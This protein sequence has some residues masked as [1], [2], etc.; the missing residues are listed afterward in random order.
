MLYIE[1]SYWRGQAWE[2]AKELA[3]SKRSGLS[4]EIPISFP[5]SVRDVIGEGG[6]GLSL[7]GYERIT[8]SGRSEW[9]SGQV[10]GPNQSK[11]PSLQMEQE[12]RFTITGT[13]GS[14][15]NVTIDQDSK[16][17]TDLENTINISYKGTEDDIIQKIEAGN[18]N[19]SL[20]GATFVGYSERV[21]GLFG[22]KSQFQIGDLSLTVIGSQEKGQHESTTIS[23]RSSV[24]PTEIDDFGYRD[25]TYF[26]IEEEF[27]NEL[28][29]SGLDIGDSIIEFKFYI[30]DRNTSNNIS[31]NAIKGEAMPH[32]GE[33]FIEN[34]GHIGFF[35]IVDQ[36]EYQIVR[37]QGWFRMVGYNTLRSDYGIACQY[38]IRDAVG[39]LDS[40][41]YDVGTD[42]TTF[43]NLIRPPNMLPENPCWDNTWRNIY[44]L[45]SSGLDPD[46]IE[47]EIFLSPVNNNIT[48]DTT[49]SPPLPLVEVFCLDKVD[50][51]GN[52]NPD[53]I[54]DRTRF[55]IGQGFLVFPVLHPFDPSDIEESQLFFGANTGRNSAMYNSTSS[56][57]INSDHKYVIRVKTGSRQNPMS[58][59][60]FNIMEGS[61]IVKLGGR[62]LQKGIDYRVDYQI[63][64]I[65]FLTDEALN[66]NV[67]LNID[68]DYEPFFM[69][70]QKALLGTRAEYR[71]GENSWLGGTVLYKS[72]TSAEN[73]PRVGR[74][75]S[76][77]FIWDTDLRLDYEVPVL[78]SLVDAIPLVHTDR[79]SRI[80]FTAE[81]AQVIGNPNTKNEAYIDDFE[82]VRNIF[83]IEVRRTIWRLSSSPLEKTQENRGRIIWY[84]PTDKVNVKEIWPNKEVAT[85]DSKTNV[86]VLSINDTS[87]VHTTDAW[88]G[89]MRY[90]ASG[91][92][93]QSRS[94]FLEVWVRGNDGKLHFDFGSIDEDIND[95]DE[96]D[97][98]DEPINGIRD[99]I[100]TTEEDVGIDG[101]PDNLEPGYNGSNDPNN[102]NWDWDP[103]DPENYSRI[104]GTEENARDPEG[105]NKPDTE[106]LNGNDFLDRYNNYFEFTID[107]SSDEFEV[108]GTRSYIDGTSEKW[109]LYRIPVQDST[110]TLVPD[111]KVYRRKEIGAP[112]W[113]QIKYI[114]LWADNIEDSTKV[115]IAQMDLVGNKWEEDSKEL[116]VTTKNTHEDAD[117]FSP[118]SVSGERSVTTGI[119]SQEQS[120]VLVFEDVKGGDTLL[121]SCTTFGSEYMNLTLYNQLE[122]WVY[123]N[124]D[125]SDDS[126]MFI[127]R[128]GRDQYN[129]Y[130]FRT[131]LQPGWEDDNKVVIDFS[132]IT[133][134]KDQVFTSLADTISSNDMDRVMDLENGS[135]YAIRG[136]PTLTDIRY[137][138]IGIANPYPYRPIS[139]EIWCD[140]LKVTDV[141][142]EP[143]W[144]E[145]SSFTI[146]FADLMD[147]NGSIERKDSE[148]HNLNEQVGSGAT[149][150]S[151]GV[152][153]KFNTHKFAPDS[154]GLSLPLSLN[155]GQTVSVPRLKTGSDISVPDSLRDEETTRTKQYSVNVTQRLSPKNPGLLVGLTLARLSHSASGG[156]RIEKSPNYPENISQD[157]NV[158]QSYDITPDKKWN[159]HLT[160]WLF[161]NRKIEVDS[162][163]EKS[164]SGEVDIKDFKTEKGFSTAGRD[165][166]E[167]PGFLDWELNLAP[168]ALRFET[169]AAARIQKRT[170]RYGS[171]TRSNEKTLDHT[172]TFNTNIIDPI[173]T[174]FTL[175]MK[176]DIGDSA[177]F[178][179]R[180]PIS[181]G[182]PLTKSIT[183][184][185][186]FSPT[187]TKWL[188][189]SYEFTSTYSE[190]TDPQR[191]TD[192]FG[193]VDVSRTYRVSMGLR[194]REL[195]KLLG[196]TG[197]PSARDPRKPRTWERDTLDLDEDNAAQTPDKK[198]G[199]SQAIGSAAGLLDRFDDVQFDWQRDDRRGLPNLAS[200]PSTA[201]QLGFT[202]DP[203]VPTVVGST[204]VTSQIESRTI[205]DNTTIRTGMR[206]PM[207]ISASL[208]YN[209][210]S[211]Q[212]YSTNNTKDTQLSFPDLTVNWNGLGKYFFFP[213][214]ASNVRTNAHYVHEKKKSYQSGD[215]VTRSKKHDLSPLV[216]MSIG[217]KFGLNTDYSTNWRDQ[218]DY[219]YST[220]NTSVTHSSEI[221]H[222]ATASYNLRGSKGIKLPIFGTIQFEN[223][224]QLSLSVQNTSRKNET[225]SVGYEDDI[226]RTQDI[227]EWSIT[228]SANYSF[229]RNIQGGMEMKWIDTKDNKL[230][231]VHHVR[232]VGIWVELKF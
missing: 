141:R 83:S 26:W 138:E 228:P 150:T 50:Q 57:E 22:I 25:L 181:I 61:E 53:G 97:S 45:G 119:M 15:I 82:G 74:E 33:T 122:M 54:V 132:V 30:D 85:E 189:Q 204:G 140:E 139:G 116:E 99:G 180:H 18:T 80:L 12:S 127:Y 4:F 147:L 10:L 95:N 107:L 206:L 38:I 166:T 128:M 156:Q 232:D 16:R 225:W 216:S 165:S 60:K 202:T 92:Q 68:F 55:D 24:Q 112:N 67:D 123:L 64:Q 230:G 66:P 9:Y 84:N 157:W 129:M 6:A 3:K 41:G 143:G 211:S 88:G 142:K 29:G 229:S 79:P 131:F 104:N 21:E 135:F 65:T 215:L 40:V 81:V 219:R 184:N 69:P 72:T 194:W 161:G 19:L 203:G 5:K 117:Y 220:I 48:S 23:G 169:S 162:I 37:T 167:V 168:T 63:G 114:R 159:V 76:R 36:Q 164:D 51:Y 137:F 77:S 90:V 153:V 179:W 227:S 126:V 125:V 224:L 154:W 109:R 185:V 207:D 28:L 100:L 209:Y 87:G 35:H 149:S 102:D 182:S 191:Y 59:G 170:D 106:D 214:L 183:E 158:R 115:W 39:G 70:E 133:A 186:R 110:F 47:V 195:T 134:F 208:K 101:L 231:K 73:R 205:S 221:T 196:D 171:A 226:A 78:T 49:Q 17:E 144:A 201:Y 198:S 34:I 98:E 124:E 120:L 121:T 1:N 2:G 188:T 193:N 13:I 44:S 146:N 223:S 46:N 32:P 8:L 210:R 177:H 113:Q 43:L 96:I 163:P 93:D 58:L 14:K 148:F 145:R 89:V 187:W 213:K 130:E 172:T 91:Y 103:D 52:A 136:S 42:S 118:P 94:M 199:L 71:F 222:K 178:R 105:G 192:Q 27:V 176:R 160:K 75:P 111:G 152:S 31:M 190:N 197:T 200:R 151:G 20:P 11:F 62:K 217:W 218:K 108:P 175:R 86:L 212:Q 173:T 56:S 7:T 155:F 174:G